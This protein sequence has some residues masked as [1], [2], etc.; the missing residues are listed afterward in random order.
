MKVVCPNCDQGFD[1][2][3]QTARGCWCYL[4][5]HRPFLRSARA[6]LCPSCLKG[7]MPPKERTFR[8]WIA[9]DGSRFSGY[10]YQPKERTVEAALLKALEPLAKQKV[11]LQVAGRTDAGVHARAQAAS[12]SF[13]TRLSSKE[14]TLAFAHRL[15]SD[16]SVWRIDEMP[17]GFDARFMSVG[18]RYI[19]RLFQG[20]CVDPFWRSRV[21]HIRKQLDVESMRLAASHFV[22]EKDFESFRS[23]ACLAAHARRYIWQLSIEQ[24]DQLIEIDVRGNAFCLNMVRVIVGTLVEVG[25]G[26]RSPK[27][28]EG[29]FMARDRTLAGKTAPAS[30]LCLEQVYY[31]DNLIEASIPTKATFPR[32]PVTSDSWPFEPAEI[33]LGP[34][35]FFDPVSSSKG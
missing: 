10:Q 25:L 23:R 20:L 14:L 13:S 34:V 12:A 27:D 32:F 4:E 15:P 16:I 29:I 17:Q 24:K 28:M 9:Y 19:Y 7:V 5:P 31:P 1:C 21:W 8:L 2:G 3:A 33:I 11:P 6:C 30:G 22:G 18:K 35:Q 26:K